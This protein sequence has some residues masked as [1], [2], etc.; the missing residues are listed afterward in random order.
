MRAIVQAHAKFEAVFSLTSACDIRHS[1]K[2]V[3]RK[4]YS[5][6]KKELRV[7][8]RT[9]RRTVAM[10]RLESGSAMIRR[11]AIRLHLQF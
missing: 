2:K 3:D 5:L 8:R 10:R 9:A 6:K 4:F 1:G 7:F 11:D